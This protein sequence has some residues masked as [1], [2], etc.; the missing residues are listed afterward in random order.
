MRQARDQR[1]AIDFE[2]VETRIV[3]D[4]QR[5]IE[6]IVPVQRNDAHKLIE[7]C[8]LCANV[9]AAGFLDQHELPGLYRVHEGPTEEKLEGLRKYLG[10]LGLDLGGGDK[11]TPSHYRDLLTQIEGREDAGL[12]QIMLLRSLRQAVYQPEN[13]GHFGLHYEAYA[14]FTSPIRR[15]PDLLL[16]RALRHIIRSR[17][18]TKWV[19]RIKGVEPI[20]VE[21]IYPYDLPD[22][23]VQGEHCSMAERRADDAT[24]EVEAW[25]KCEYLQE[26]VGEQFAGVIAAVTSFG[27]FVELKDI[28]IEGLVHIS[29]LPGD[30]YHFDPAKQR[31]TGERSGRHFKLGDHLDV[32]VAR[33]NL[34]DKKIDLELLEGSDRGAV[35]RDGAKR[36]GARKGRGKTDRTKAGRGKAE[37][38]KAGSKKDGKGTVK[39]KI[40]AEAR[41]AAKK[42]SKKT[43]SKGAKARKA[44][45]KKRRSK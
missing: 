37:R 26:H 17:R 18:R 25:L 22:M 32:Q 11:P 39:A 16:H 35:K 30:Y 36:D 1:G 12:I 5:K 45:A 13:L 44:K 33:V 29:S 10:E 42:K 38:K 31:L 15:Y 27:L 2:T 34:D 7:E 9:A 21:H 23:L 6:K 28:Y 40:E 14:H 8:M 20:P 43:P 4:Q 3:F 24:R 19:R 41:K